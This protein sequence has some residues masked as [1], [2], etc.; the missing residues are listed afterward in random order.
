MRIS[1]IPEFKDKKHV[2]I[3][4]KDS[5]IIDCV[6]KMSKNNYGSIIIVEKKKP[7]GIFTE[8]DLL[9]KV[10][11]KNIDPNKHTV[12]KVMTKNLSTAKSEDQIS[13]TLRRMSQGHF[14]HMPIIDADGNINGIISQGD[15][16]S[17]SWSEIF[18]FLGQ[19]TKSSF[20]THTQIWM[21]IIALGIYAYI[22]MLM[23]K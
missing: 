9:N 18:H 11:A 4:S 19:K 8:R 5:K 10:V 7:V 14:R 13:T 16:V 2:L 12:E 21:L 17:Y 6:K 3:I 20:M 1:D 23:I 22:A 15:L